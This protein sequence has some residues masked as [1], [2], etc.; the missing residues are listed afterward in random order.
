MIGNNYLKLKLLKT[1]IPFKALYLY[2]DI[3][4]VKDFKKLSNKE[5]YFTL[6][7][8]ST[9]WYNKPFKYISWPHFLEEHHFLS[10]ESF[11]GYMFSVWCKLIHFSL[12]WNPGIHRMGN[13]AKILCLSPYEE[14]KKSLNPIFIF[15][16]K[17]SNNT[18]DFIQWTINLNYSF[19]IPS[20][21]FQK[22]PENFFSIPWWCTVK[23][24]THT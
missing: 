23:N 14:N 21:L 9:K 13:T 7:A 18:L 22:P 2:K 15:Y 4:K 19:N 3:S 10:Q 5:I 11:D 8:N 12:P 24:F 20:S 16:C 17:L 1:K 6:Q